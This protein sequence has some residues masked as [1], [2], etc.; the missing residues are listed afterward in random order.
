MHRQDK[1]WRRGCRSLPL[2]CITYVQY[3]TRG[4]RPTT[5]SSSGQRPR[6]FFGFFRASEITVPLASASAYDTAVNLSWGDATD[7]LVVR[8]F[9]KRSKTD[10]FG[11]GTEV[12]LGATGNDICPVRAVSAYVARQGTSPRAFFH[13][14]T[15]IP[16][17][18]AKFI[19]NVRAALM[20][21]GIPETGYSGHS[22]LLG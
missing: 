7:Q 14:E 22:F 6:C 2:S 9:L 11:R 17:T 16:M 3:T 8:V 15:G 20:R 18:K 21:G 19:K 5:I 12:F 13:F 4:S 1:L 10:Q